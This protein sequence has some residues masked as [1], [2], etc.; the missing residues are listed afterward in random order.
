MSITALFK[1]MFITSRIEVMEFV[2]SY[3]VKWVAT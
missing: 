2:I 3:Y 1:V